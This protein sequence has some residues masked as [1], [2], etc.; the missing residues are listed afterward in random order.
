[1][2][3]IGAEYRERQRRVAA[4]VDYDLLRAVV[5]GADVVKAELSERERLVVDNVGA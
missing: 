1:L 5:A 4:R 2:R 3:Q